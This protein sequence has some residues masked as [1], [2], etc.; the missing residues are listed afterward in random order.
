MSENKPTQIRDGVL[1][2]SKFENISDTGA[3]YSYSFSKGYKDKEDNWKN[4]T[5]LNKSDLL[6][7][8][9]LLIKAYNSD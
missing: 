2:I 7:L 1:S 8:A 6:R 4:T 5:N 9:N 3:F